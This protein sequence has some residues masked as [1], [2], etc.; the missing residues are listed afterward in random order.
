[1]STAEPESDAELANRL[2][3]EAGRILVDLR[4]AMWRDGAHAWDVMDHGDATAH[5]FIAR[6]LRRLR[7]DDAVLDEEGRE[8]PRR[9]DGGRVW[10]IDPLDGTREFGEAGRHDWAVHVALWHDDRFLAGA[11][12][13]PVLGLVLSTDPA[14]AL[15][16]VDRERPR[17]IT[18][19]HRAPYAA[20]VVAND[21]GCDA[22]RLGSAGAKAMAVVL[23]EADIYVH[24]GG[25]YQWDSAAP[26]AVALAAG[27]H[28]SRI[29]GSP[30]VYNARDPWLPDLIIC[31][32]ELAD[33]VLGA[34]WGS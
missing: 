5:Q 16:P 24:D 32:P 29:D 21:L 22:M 13:L 30:I 23:G 9:F 4:E 33:A 1:M 14:P 19:R 25:M 6:E 10:I 27:L 28:V 34:L 31:R 18:S 15:P 7:P 26:A 12:A 11:V 20:V 2:A 8:D 17:L 3:H